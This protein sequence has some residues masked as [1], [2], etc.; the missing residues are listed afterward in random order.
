MAASGAPK[1]T[2]R[3]GRQLEPFVRLHPYESRHPPEHALSYLRLGDDN[4]AV[5]YRW[6]GDSAPG[7]NDAR[8]LIG[9]S[10]ILTVP[11][12][13]ALESWPGWRAYTPGTLLRPLTGAD[14]A[15]MSE[16]GERD[17]Q[18]RLPF[19][20]DALEIV[21]GR[22]L[23]LPDQPVSILGCPVQDRPAMVWALHR[24]AGGH[25]AAG[26]MRRDWSYSTYEDDHDDLAPG[27]PGIGFLPGAPRRQSAVSRNVINLERDI[28]LPL[29]SAPMKDVRVLL[30]DAGFVLMPIVR[31]GGSNAPSATTDNPPTS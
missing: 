26:G 19:L 2:A 10:T 9:P 20:H 5:V 23:E 7:R 25:L 24:I 3:W 31:P 18:Q 28:A 1:Q 29:D 15:R 30:R 13:L 21:L 11:T 27:W 6:A 14:I 16:V 22:I 17:L 8:A 4:A 12:S